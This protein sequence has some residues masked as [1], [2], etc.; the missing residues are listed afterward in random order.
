MTNKP[1][2]KTLFIAWIIIL[3]LT[4]CI[5]QSTKK[6]NQTSSSDSIKSLT[7]ISRVDSLKTIKQFLDSNTLISFIAKISSN[8]KPPT[9]GKPFDTLDFNKVIAYE[10]EG[11]E[12]PYPSVINENGKF[13]PVIAKQNALT[14]NEVNELTQ[15]LCSSS[16]YGQSTAACFVP[17][18]GIVFYKNNKQRAQV[19]ICLGCNYLISSIPILAEYKKK[20][21]A[22]TKNE[23]SATGFS[24]EGRTRIKK[25]CDKYG[26]FYE[27]KSMFDKAN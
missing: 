4:S 17:H 1:Y 27:K 21:N 14:Q 13:V 8:I 7:Q 25:L 2:I 23:Y 12:E 9:N 19:N 24:I 10:F 5:N 11:S 18:L 16:T 15:L 3:V 22:G 20:I 26:Y 6:N